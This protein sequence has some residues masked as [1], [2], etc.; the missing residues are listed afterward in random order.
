MSNT[1]LNTLRSTNTTF[2]PLI[3]SKGITIDNPGLVEITGNY[4]TGKSTLC[5]SIAKANSL[6]DTVYI[7]TED[8][9]NI[10]MFTYI[11]NYSKVDN[12]EDRF[13]LMLPPRLNDLLTRLEDLLLCGIKLIIIDS[14][15]VYLQNNNCKDTYS[16]LSSLQSL[17]IKY[18]AFILIT[19]QYRGRGI[20]QGNILS[21]GVIHTSIITLKCSKIIKKSK[22]K[23]L[24]IYTKVNTKLD[25]FENKIII[26]LT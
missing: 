1:L 9:F 15:T 12:L 18:S 7:E 2:T 3:I 20:P 17:A 14:I 5:L 16:V 11:N 13:L 6:L 19:T 26:N 25:S 22:A 4:S 21:R 24:S 8:S 10:P 23:Y